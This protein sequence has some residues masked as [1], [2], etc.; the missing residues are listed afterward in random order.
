MSVLPPIPDALPNAPWSANVHLAY[1]VLTDMFTHASQAVRQSDS[2]PL[3]IRF[4]LETIIGTAVPILQALETS[5][6]DEG[7]PTEWLH[8]CAERL[9]ELVQDLQKAEKG[10]KGK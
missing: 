8:L 7:I 5:A 3:R 10:A 2:D 4:H 9:G 6:G 1:Q